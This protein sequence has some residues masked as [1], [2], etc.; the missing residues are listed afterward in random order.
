MT[1]TRMRQIR[2]CLGLT[3]RQACAAMGMQ[4]ATERKWRRWEKGQETIPSGV[5]DDWE[6]LADQHG[7]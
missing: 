4:P 7:V 2:L 6:E 1:G 5:A 3:V